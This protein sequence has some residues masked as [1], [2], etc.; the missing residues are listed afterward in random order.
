MR[1]IL[2]TI[3]LVSIF[4]CGSI[5]MTEVNA[6]LRS[7][8]MELLRTLQI[9][10]DQLEPRNLETP[11][12]ADGEAVATIC[13]ADDPAWREAAEA[14]QAGIADAT[15][16]EVPLATDAALSDEEAF[17]Q[18]LVLLGH[19]D[20]NEHVARL[21]H[22]F[23]VCLDTA[24]AGDEGYVIRSA[25]DPWGRGYNAIL[26][27][28]STAAGT[29]NAAQAFGGLV[30]DAAEDNSLTLGRQMVLEI[31]QDEEEFM[32]PE[33]L[34]EQVE[35]DRATLMAPGEGRNGV[36]RL[37]GHG[38]EYY[39]TGDPLAGEAYRAMMHALVEY[40][41]TDP[42]ISTEPLSRYDRDFRDAWTYRVGILWDLLEED[43]LFTDEERVEFTNM[44]IRLMLECD[45]YQRYEARLDM[46]RENTEVPHNHHT[47][48]ALGAYFIGEYALRHY[49]G[50]EPLADRAEMWLEVAEGVFR[51]LKHSWKPLEDAAAYI[52]LPIRH[53]MTY[54]LATGDT[55]WF[56][57]GHGLEA[58]EVAMVTMDNAGYQAA[59]GDHSAYTANSGM[60]AALYKIAWYHRD[61]E[62]L[63]MTQKAGGHPGF[64]FH[65]SYHL[66]I[67]PEPPTGHIG[68]TVVELPEAAYN[69]GIQESP[70]PTQPLVPLEDCFD[71]M[72]LRAGLDVDDAYM[73]LDGFG[74]GNH[75]HWD[76]NAIIRYSDGGEPL[77]VDGE[78]IKNAPKYHNAMVIL[79]DGRSEEAPAVTE[80]VA[81]ER[82]DEVSFAQTR[83]PEYNGAAWTRS[84]VWR[85]NDYVLVTDEVEALQEGDFTLRCC[86][87]PW[88]DATLE[89]GLCEVTHRP[90]KL[91]VRNL[92]GA[93]SMIEEMKVTANMPVSRLSQQVSRTMAAGES[94]RFANV[95]E[96]HPLAQ[97]REV[98][99][100]RVG[101]GLFVVE[102]PE[103][104]EVVA[105]GAAGLAS[106][107]IEGD[108]SM[109]LIG[110]DLL[111]ATG[112]TELSPGGACEL[113]EVPAAAAEVRE[114][115]L[116][117][118]A[119]PATEDGTGIDAPEL[120][121]A[122][123]AGGFDAPLEALPVVDLTADAEY[124]GRYGPIDK[125][126]DGVSSNSMTSVQ[127][128]PG[129]SP[130]ITMQLAGETRI[131]SVE[132]RDWS[133]MNENWEMASRRL[134]ISS[135]GFEDDV[136][137]L[138]EAFE[139]TGTQ[140]WGGNV[141]TI[142]TAE[143][144]QVASDVRLILE[145]ADR[146]DARVYVAEV[147]V[148]GS[149]PGALPKI[150]AITSGDLA[151][152]GDTG[153]VVAGSDSGQIRAFDAAGEV[154]WAW[155]TDGRAPINALA[156]ADIDGDG[157]DEVVYGTDGARLGL[158]SADGEAGWE[159]TPPKYRGIDSDVMNIT[160]ADLDGDGLPEIVAGLRSWQYAAFDAEGEVLWTNV[161]YAHPATVCV[162]DDFD[163][164]G[165]PEFVGGNQY[166]RLNLIDTDGERIYSYDRFGPE[167]TAV[168]SSDVD[169]DDLPEIIMG[170]D[171]GELICFDGVNRDRLW[172]KNVGDRVTRIV[173][174]DINGDG[175]EEIVCGAESAN[176]YAFAPDGELLWRTA[177]PGGVTDL[178]LL[179]GEEVRFAAAAGASGVVVLDAAGEIVASGSADERA[180]QLALL[181]GQV[182]VTMKA[183][184]IVT[185]DVAQ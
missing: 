12:V 157:R 130:T 81:A 106:A 34:E 78:Y 11:I 134:Q 127:W 72:S 71:K 49:P 62:V 27:G 96:S 117:M 58:A 159:V 131:T 89:G 182:A 155:Q 20:N 14:V 92:D 18:S 145:P 54:S 107:G 136:R 110:E 30:A 164:D 41:E 6:D 25:H 83:L 125:L 143:V 175:V 1:Q 26:V 185:F 39:R 171:L 74:R 70:Y 109:V 35:Q 93:P 73:L 168:A 118:P 162:A 50:H 173:A 133:S 60:A 32:T 156:C 52:W 84:V 120:A 24:Y 100:R 158:L 154:L 79:R 37:I 29:A 176:V 64:P 5:F 113:A 152:D 16:V 129:V 82:M 57:E 46:W 126:V 40:F 142:W 166:Y 55:T 144:N 172:T 121:Q 19:L 68:L 135:D 53:V 97:P 75:M 151:G 4:A 111:V 77:L 15:G 147:T 87:R 153:A 88:G 38:R 2:T 22:N 114:R 150:T 167:Q 122:W 43:D 76:A 132:L 51:G 17:G 47:F 104:A 181:D 124:F 8:Q 44:V 86:W 140:R 90:M 10:A 66:D 115:V 65:Q 165:L 3:A 45:L 149:R 7:E 146:E 102:R 98:T 178:A 105:L 85:P 112:N 174:A 123:E 36:A 23:Y 42:Y 138:G 139:E 141:N 67:A 108:A 48:P 148:R 61:P 9:S 177:L 137:D 179:P 94:Y 33:E 28:G 128:E 56:D 161:I 91:Q 116:G 119:A 13:H 160:P 169:G 95:I 21:Y 103:G 180:Q 69:E 63:W 59:Y 31:G 170:T 183:G 163:G 80:L 101:E 99:A 184:Q